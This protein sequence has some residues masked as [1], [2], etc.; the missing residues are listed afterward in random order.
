MHVQC[1][2]T[3]FRSSD[4][5]SKARFISKSKDSAPLDPGSKASFTNVLAAIS[6]TDTSLDGN[7]FLKLFEYLA[8][9]AAVFTTSPL[10]KHS[11]GNNITK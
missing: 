8:I 6:I 3:S 11:V 2:L 7:K 9:R 4:N 1:I 10:I 5:H